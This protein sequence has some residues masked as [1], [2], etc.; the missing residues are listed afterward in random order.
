MGPKYNSKYTYKREADGEL[1]QRGKGNYYLRGRYWS[2]VATSQGMLQPLEAGKK[3]NGLDPT[4]S[5][6]READTLILAQ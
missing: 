6:Q 5:L 4:Q 2:D 1:T 3:R